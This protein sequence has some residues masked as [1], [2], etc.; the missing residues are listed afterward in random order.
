M[1]FISH[2]FVP[3][4]NPKVLVFTFYF[5]RNI[6]FCSVD[7]LFSLC[8]PYFCVLCKIERGGKTAQTTGTKSIRLPIKFFDTTMSLRFRSDLASLKEV[9]FKTGGKQAKAVR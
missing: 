7:L 2:F 3:K 6:I 8:P 1:R 9:D 4:Y 5:K